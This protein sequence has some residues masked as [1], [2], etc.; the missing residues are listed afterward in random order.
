MRTLTAKPSIHVLVCVC[1]M[2][3]KSLPSSGNLLWTH[4][5]AT[6]NVARQKQDIVMWPFAGWR[7]GRSHR[8]KAFPCHSERSLKWLERGGGS[9][10]DCTHRSQIEWKTHQSNAFILI[11]CGE[12][13]F[14]HC[15]CNHGL[16]TIHNSLNM[17]TWSFVVRK[18][19][20]LPFQ[21]LL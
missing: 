7:R 20:H 10:Q 18:T 14:W 3:D 6:I 19:D 15:C 2:L 21:F 4:P 16:T 17:E 13:W 11:T 1:P 5:A 8:E 12:M 9:H